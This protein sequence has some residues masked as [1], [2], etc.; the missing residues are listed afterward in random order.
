MLR[1]VGSAE[2]RR[3]QSAVRRTVESAERRRV[4]VVNVMEIT[5]SILPIVGDSSEKC[6]KIYK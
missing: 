4:G 3:V 5:K 2:R 6:C 1:R